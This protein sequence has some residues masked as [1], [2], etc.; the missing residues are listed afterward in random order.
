[1]E[2]FG[3]GTIGM[4]RALS[5]F[6]GL[7]STG[8]ICGAVTGGLFCLGLYFGDDDVVKYVNNGSAIAAAK[9]FL[10]QF[11]EE[12]GWLECK[13]IQKL[14]LGRFIDSKAVEKD[15][16]VFVKA[17]GYQKC[18]LPAGIGARL[19]ASIILEDMIVKSAPGRVDND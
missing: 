11:K 1:M 8:S 5:P 17:K 16:L 9:K 6:P 13:R 2:E 15:R 3:L 19:S 14:V 7:G 18:G 10:S 12:L 4:V